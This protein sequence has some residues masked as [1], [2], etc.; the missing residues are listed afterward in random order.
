MS[1]E[2]LPYRIDIP[3][4]D[5]DDLNDRLARTR[6]PDELPG[7]GWSYGVPLARVRELAEYWRTGYDWRAHEAR[8]NAFPQFT[9]VIDGERTH[10]L[11]V[12]SPEPTAM[13]LI[14]SHG[15]PSTVADFLDLLGPLSDPGAY[16]GDPADAFHVVVPSLPGYG[17]SGPTRS[18]GWDVARVARPRRTLRRTPGTR[19][20]HRGRPGVLP[21]APLKLLPRPAIFQLS[22]TAITRIRLVFDSCPPQASTRRSAR[23]FAVV[24]NSPPKSS[25]VRS[26]FRF[27]AIARPCSDR[28]PSPTIDSRS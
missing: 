11:H 9:T 13:P 6:W 1:D 27:L 12:R 17:F 4:A 2:I 14:L 25:T 18:A 15:W 21:P 23:C 22:H 20:A 10:F 3:Q 7:A 5:L 8:L 24:L 16:G 19:P 28:R 26:A